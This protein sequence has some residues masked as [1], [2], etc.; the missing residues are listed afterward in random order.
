M[1]LGGFAAQDVRL[2]RCIT[3]GIDKVPGREGG[4]WFGISTT[5]RIALVTNYRQGP[6]Y[7]VRG[8]K[9]RGYLVSDFLKS[10]EKVDEY[11][12]KVTQAG[13]YYNGFNLIV[14]ELSQ[15]ESF[16][17]RYHC[18]QEHQPS[19]KLTPGIYGLSNRYLDYEWQKVRLGKQRF[20]EILNLSCPNEKKITLLLELLQDETR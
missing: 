16:E 13:G 2:R 7:Y 18:N 4:T 14:G 11:I 10:D 6:S 5:G 3:L 12:N 17:F 15:N 20:A 9:S 8:R 1:V 19:G